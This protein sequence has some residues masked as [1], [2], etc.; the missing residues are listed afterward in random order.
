MESWQR[1]ALSTAL[2][3]LSLLTLAAAPTAASRAAVESAALP[4]ALAPAPLVYKIYTK[5]PVFFIT[6]DDGWI[7]NSAARKYLLDNQIPTTQFLLGVIWKDPTRAKFFRALVN[8]GAEVGNHTATHSMLSGISLYTAKKAI[9]RGRD[10]VKL[11]SGVTP[12]WLRPPT[13]AIDTTGR[14]AA[15]ACGQRQVVLWSASAD[16][17]RLS[18]AG[19]SVL[20]KGD[21]VLLHWNSRSLYTL[22]NIIAKA[23]AQGLRPAALGDYLP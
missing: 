16:G 11:G 4:A 15:T 19:G 18:L 8:R 14:R 20:R 22:K 6:M 12:E 2:A 10:L 17:S 23:K 13:G 7:S 5:D 9:C 21:I 3:A 1:V